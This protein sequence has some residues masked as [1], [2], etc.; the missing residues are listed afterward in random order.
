MLPKST[1]MV[2]SRPGTLMLSVP[3]SCAASEP[4]AAT[5]CSM[6]RD[7]TRAT[8]TGRASSEPTERRET[9]DF[10]QESVTA[11]SKADGYTIRL[12]RDCMG[13]AYREQARLATGKQ[14]LPSRYRRRL[15]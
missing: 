8:R 2:C 1:A 14:S 9:S 3:W 5:V 13:E 6:D 15:G 12:K 7:S 10:E 11:A 4:M